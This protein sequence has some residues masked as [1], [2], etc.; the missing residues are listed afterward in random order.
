M[1]Y[2]LDRPFPAERVE[3]CPDCGHPVLYHSPT[4]AYWH[5]D[6]YQCFLHIGEPPSIVREFYAKG[7][8]HA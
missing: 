4:G 8:T 6:G 1:T 5:S 7:A 3:D 2:D